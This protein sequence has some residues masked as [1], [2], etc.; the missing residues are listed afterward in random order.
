MPTP[1]NL[2]HP[3]LPANGAD[4]DA[5][6][7]KA[8]QDYIVGK[9]TSFP[10]DNIQTKTVAE[11]ALTDEVNPRLYRAEATAN[12]VVSGGLSSGF[13]GFSY[14]VPTG[15]A[16]T[17]GHRASIV[18][19]SFTAT[20]SRDT[21][22]SVHRSG[23]INAPQEVL[24]G[25]ATPALPADSQW[26]QRVVS[27][28]TAIT[29]ITDLRNLSS[30]GQGAIGYAQATS[31]SAS[32]TG[33]TPVDILGLSVTVNVPT[34]GRRVKVTGYASSNHPNNSV[35]TFLF[36]NE[37]GTNKQLSPIG[38]ILGSRQYST[39]VTYINT[40]SAGLHTYKLQASLPVDPGT[41]T[42]SPGAGQPFFIL[43]EVL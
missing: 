15:T 11:T 32:I 18:A 8:N 33:A 29:S 7:I 39:T 28:T 10:G 20:A 24:N 43:V 5:D 12:F 42:M 6:P 40:P 31:G 4:F 27:G 9:L 34:G 30:T 35:T 38:H 37:D 26:L 21:Y 23:N 2:P 41:A 14:T 13:T 36:V 17:S 25:A 16:Y 22:I 19:Q 3:N 1:I